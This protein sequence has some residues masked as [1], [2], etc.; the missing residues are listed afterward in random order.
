MREDV[1]TKINLPE[2]RVQVGKLVS[3]CCMFFVFFPVGFDPG[4][5]AG[6]EL[7]LN[8]TKAKKAKSLL[9]MPTTVC[10]CQLNRFLLF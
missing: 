1:A 3:V 7:T 4:T 2:S 5:A 9:N 10:V 6:K 8:I